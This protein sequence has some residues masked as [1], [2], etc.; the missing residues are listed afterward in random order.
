MTTNQSSVPSVPW[1][2]RASVWLG[3]GI[4]PASISTGGGLATQLP[5]TTLLWVLP[6]GVLLLTLL[7]TGQGLLGR[8][9]RQRLA[10]IA[11]TTFGATWGA[12]LLNLLMALGMVG[13]GGFQGG[14]AG[15]SAAQLFHLPGW[16][17]ALLVVVALYLLSEFGL[18]RWAAL[19]WVT[20]GAAIALTLFALTTIDLTF[21]MTTA[22]AMPTSGTI[23]WAV[24]TIISYATLFSLRTPDFTW[25]LATERDVLKANLFFFF[26]LLFSMSV[27][28][29]LYHA[30]GSWNIADVLRQAHSA[31]L[32]HLFLV[33]AVISPLVSGWYS[34]ALALSNLT[35]LTTRQS[36]LLI[37]ALGFVLA[38]TRFDQR[39]L[40][41]LGLLGASLAPAL[42]TIL[43]VSWLRPTP[44]T[45][46]AFSAWIA[47]AAVAILMQ[48]QGQSIH[49][50]TGALTSSGLT[51]VLHWRRR[52]SVLSH[53]NN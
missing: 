8:R 38:A 46:Q 27:G 53:R 18:N 17:G 13:W 49:L 32:G 9:R 40:P 6:L 20:T 31:A 7:C 23:L 39:L 50:F 1:R 10:Q 22:S 2:R 11:I 43:W 42:I 24:G 35:P 51:L 14:V 5:L 47:G 33:V 41:F 48:A 45:A 3:I 26:P 36:T 19:A 25:D 15:A 52:Q 44:S 4:N 12:G 29:L 37:C 16:T 30:T 34:G 21:P 28:A